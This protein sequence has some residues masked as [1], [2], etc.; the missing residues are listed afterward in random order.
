MIASEVHELLSWIDAKGLDASYGKK[1]SALLAIP[2]LWTPPFVLLSCDEVSGIVEGR[3]LEEV[4]GERQLRRIFALAKPHQRIILRSSIVGESIWDRGRYESEVLPM[5]I[6]AR[7]GCFT[8][9]AGRIAASAGGRRVGLVAQRHVEASYQGEFGNLLRV[10]KTRDHWE[11]SVVDREG[12]RVSFRSNSQRDALPDTTRRLEFRSFQQSRRVFGA[13]GAW[14]NQILLS[15]S[16]RRVTAEWLLEGQ[17]CYVV[18]VDDEDED[19]FGYNPFE[20]RIRPRVKPLI[21]NT[22][23]FKR[24]DEGSIRDW[25]KLG[26]LEELWEPGDPM[27]PELFVA[28]LS[29]M[30]GQDEQE[31]EV[32]IR[33]DLEQLFGDGGIVVRTSNRSGQEGLVNLPRSED[34]SPR[35]AASWCVERNRLLQSQYPEDELA[36][37][38]HGFIGASGSAWVRAEPEQP[39]VE[40]HALWGLPDALQFCPYD[41]WEVH[42]PTGWTTNYPNYKSGMLIST[43][44]GNWKYERVKNEL[45]RHNCISE[46]TAKELAYRS[47]AIAKRM[48]TGCHIMWFIGCLDGKGGRY[49]MPWYWTKTHGVQVNSDRLTYDSLVVTDRGDLE[50]MIAEFKPKSRRAL[51]FRPST[52]ELMRDNDFIR[53]VGRT[54]KRLGVPVILF[55]STLAHA[56]YLLHKEECTIITPSEGAYKRAR[57]KQRFGKLVRDKIPELI[58]SKWEKTSV[59][60]AY[61]EEK[62]AYLV[63]KLIEEM[64]EARTAMG[65]RERIEELGDLFEVLRA[66]AEVEDGSIEEVQELAE[67]KRR[68]AGG[69]EGGTILEETTI[70]AA[71]GT[72]QKG[73]DLE[74]FSVVAGGREWERGRLGGPVALRGEN[75]IEV[76]FTFFGFAELGKYW[77]ETLDEIGV[78]LS[79]VLQ[80]DRFEIRV[81]RAPEQVDLPFD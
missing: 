47:R 28:R 50:Q 64:L 4:L 57:R 26:V 15:G 9:A 72:A 39:T 40:I 29:D 5:D 61:G 21:G 12:K 42:T 52:L 17:H 25:D 74:Y 27:L 7:P 8:G 51:E 45:A 37:V 34:V 19:V 77:I 2:R 18:Q 59:R 36:F 54:A 76:P 63:G 62:R 10:S 69:F 70:P 79:V 60:R 22:R 71:H 20:Q 30:H 32:G 31:L 14:L 16:G 65:R 56:Y 13:L 75:G 48:N 55:G 44:T 78:H 11:I 81:S 66:L 35:E 38:A 58:Q 49:N 73:K 6:A 46:S 3:T 41:R 80:S 23:F 1:G 68:R 67:R 24:A 53:A 33:N 43:G